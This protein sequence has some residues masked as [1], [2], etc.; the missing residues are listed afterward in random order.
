VNE[1]NQINND[2]AAVLGGEKKSDAAPT[3]RSRVIS[4]NQNQIHTPAA[5][6]QPKQ[7]GKAEY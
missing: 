1:I 4:T 7:H 6:N 3:A 5:Q 2:R